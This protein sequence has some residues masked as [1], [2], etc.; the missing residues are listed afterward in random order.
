MRDLRDWTHRPQ[1][2]ADAR[3]RLLDELKRIQEAPPSAEELKLWKDYVEGTVARRME[4]YSGIARELVL[5]AFYDLG[6]YFA[7]EYP[8]VLRE[9]TADEVH[10]A[11][12]EF[13]HPAGYVAVI[14]GP[15]EELLEE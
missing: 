8:G 7:Y 3:R 11:A 2:L 6:L 1:V 9:I 15:V 4:T 5:A 10:E 14:A 13:L 12:R